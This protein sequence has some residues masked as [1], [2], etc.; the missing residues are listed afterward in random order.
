MKCGVNFIYMGIK[1]RTQQF[2]F[3]RNPNNV[4]DL[5]HILILS[6]AHGFRL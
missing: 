2:K 3:I 4:I 5:S 1:T 6:V